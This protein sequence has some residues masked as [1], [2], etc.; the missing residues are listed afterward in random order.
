MQVLAEFAST[1]TG[2][3]PKGIRS[4]IYYLFDPILRFY[5]MRLSKPVDALVPILREIDGIRLPYVRF[6]DARIKRELIAL[7]VDLI[8]LLE[9]SQPSSAMTIAPPF[10]GFLP[11]S[12]GNRFGVNVDLENYIDNVRDVFSGF[13]HEIRQFLLGIEYVGP[14]R[15][16]PER[17]YVATGT[18]PDIGTSGENAVPILWLDQSEKVECKTKPGQ[19][20]T[21]KRLDV[22]VKEWFEEFGIAHSLHITRPTRAIYQAELD[23]PPTSSTRVTIADVGFGV[24]QLLPVIVAGMRAPKK[25]TLI[26]EQPEIHLHPKLQAKL[27]DFLICITELDKRVIVETHSE[28]LINMLRLR[29]VEDE[30][31][32]LQDRIAILFVQA[33][34]TTSDDTSVTNDSTPR[35]G[36]VLSNLQLDTY[37]QIVNWPVDFFPEYGN[38]NERILRA[39]MN[40]HARMQR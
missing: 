32:M 10:V 23:G 31:G 17:V 7:L 3:V 13:L 24:S 35:K 16:K 6:W 9:T 40:R 38:I 5:G 36:S 27:A 19:L 18:P 39:M 2:T 11:G 29:I 33:L 28:H 14:L 20:P 12:T 30:S 4:E 26:F 15:A 22:A 25:S 37:G 34:S 21:S 1:N 8:L